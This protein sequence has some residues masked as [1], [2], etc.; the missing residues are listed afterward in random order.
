M[1]TTPIDDNIVRYLICHR[2]QVRIL[3]FAAMQPIHD[4]KKKS[5]LS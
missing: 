4:D 5:N 1:G 3:S 2:R